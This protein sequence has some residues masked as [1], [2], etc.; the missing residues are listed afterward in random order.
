M[1]VDTRNKRMSMIGLAQVVP[2]VIPDP[3]GGVDTAAE[4][5]QHIGLYSGI[6]AGAPPVSTLVGSRTMMDAGS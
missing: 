5:Q 6:D 1:A 4:R 3:D 2:R